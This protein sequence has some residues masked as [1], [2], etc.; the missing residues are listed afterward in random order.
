MPF[1]FVCIQLAQCSV[2]IVSSY[3]SFRKMNTKLFISLVNICYVFYSARISNR[4]IVANFK[5]SFCISPN[6]FPLI[7]C[8][9]VREYHCKICIA[10]VLCLSFSTF[11]MEQRFFSHEFLL[12]KIHIETATNA[13]RYVQCVSSSPFN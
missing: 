12:F 9:C 1:H 8:D 6:C 7:I 11:H 13:I 4:K 2:L 3:F 5:H 10:F